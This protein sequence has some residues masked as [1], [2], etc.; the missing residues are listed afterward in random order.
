MNP[1]SVAQTADSG[2]RVLFDA[3]S[4]SVQDRHT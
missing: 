4:V 1:L 3:D 2:C